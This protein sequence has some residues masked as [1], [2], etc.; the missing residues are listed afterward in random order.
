MVGGVVPP[1]GPP[2]GTVVATGV[3]SMP[4]G[5][6]NGSRAPAMITGGSVGRGEVVGV[7]EGVSGGTTTEPVGPAASSSPSPANTVVNRK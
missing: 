4:G 1:V 2:V 3:A 5:G 6:E 7:A